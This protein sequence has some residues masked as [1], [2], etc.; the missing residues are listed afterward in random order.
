[1]HG[2]PPAPRRDKKGDRAAHNK[3]LLEIGATEAFTRGLIRAEDYCR[4]SRAL[5]EINAK[6][7]G[8]PNQLSHLD[9]HWLWGA[10]G[11]G[12]SKYARETW[13]N[14][15]LKD[16]TKWWD[17]YDGQPNILV[18]DLDPDHKF[19]AKQLKNWSD[20]YP[21]TPEIKGGRLPPIRPASIIVT[22]QYKPEQIFTD[23]DATAIRRRFQ[24]RHFGGFT[25]APRSGDN[26][27]I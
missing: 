2:D 10:T 13:P 26:P 27:Q 20:H 23:E 11:T 18:D 9:N 5:D 6:T 19:M 4:V 1:M 7:A 21:F 22:S 25:G 24:V 3:L 8:M 14:H 16:I 12:K 15:Y 17:H